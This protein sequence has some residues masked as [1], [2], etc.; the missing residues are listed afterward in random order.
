MMIG[1]LAADAGVNVA[2]LRYYERRGLLRDPERLPSG[3]RSCLSATVQIVRFIKH[4]QELGFTLTDIE[5][6]LRLAAGELGSCKLVRAVATKKLD[7]LQRKIAMLQAMRRSLK[8]LV[9]T[10]DLPRAKRECQ[11]LQAIEDAA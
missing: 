8:R 9:E 5:H 4:A 10:C 1:E 7:E 3:Y 11:L 6:L 2:T